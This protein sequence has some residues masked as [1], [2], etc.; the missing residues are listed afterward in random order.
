MNE[1]VKEYK[2]AL[3]DRIFTY[4]DSDSLLKDVVKSLP[5]KMY[6]NDDVYTGIIQ[7]MKPVIDNHLSPEAII[8]NEI[9]LDYI[10]KDYRGSDKTKQKIAK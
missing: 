3:L 6:D 1:S 5:R 8:Q 10:Y 2:Q 9:S 7:E 4:F